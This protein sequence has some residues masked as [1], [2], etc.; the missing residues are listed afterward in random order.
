[1]IF[2]DVVDAAGRRRC[3]DDVSNDAVHRSHGG[4]RGLGSRGRSPSPCRYNRQPASVSSAPPCWVLRG[5]SASST[6]HLLNG[7]RRDVSCAGRRRTPREA[8]RR[9]ILTALSFH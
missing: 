5:I 1:M 2:A 4:R 3:A 8:A 6:I 7:R 9:A